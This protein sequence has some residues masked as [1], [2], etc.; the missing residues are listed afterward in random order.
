MELLKTSIGRL[1]IAGILEGLSLI[2][3]MGF[4]MPM[5][6]IWGDPSFV[7]MIGSIHGALFILFAIQLYLTAEEKNWKYQDLPL[8]LMIS[9][10]IPFGTFYL[11]H[12]ILKKME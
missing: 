7:R 10:F 2:V 8:K 4:A 3:L 12:K 1:R 6:Y 5:K 9:C 11:D